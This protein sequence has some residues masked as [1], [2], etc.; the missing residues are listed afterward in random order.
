M[1]RHRPAALPTR[2]EPSAKASPLAPRAV[3]REFHALLDSGTRLVVD[4]GSRREPHSLLA[5]GYT[6]KLAFELF[7][8]RFYLA[9]VR[10]N[11]LLRFFVAWVVPPGA[12]R[13]HA[14]IFYK[15]VSL[16]W[17]CGS[18]GLFTDAELWIGKGATRFERRGGYELEHTIES[19]T[20]LPFEMQ[21]VLDELMRRPEVI[22]RDTEVLARVLRNAP[23]HR[24][25][26]YADFLEPRRRAMADPRNRIHGG[27]PIARFRRRHDPGSLEIAAG[28]EPDFRRGRI[29]TTRGRSASYGGVVE[30]HRIL[31]RNRRVQWL[32]FAAPRHVWPAPPQALTTELSSYGVRTV[33]VVV[34]DE[35]CLPGYEYHYLND[36]EF[37]DSLHSQI[38]PGFAGPANPIDPDRADASAW[39]DRLPVVAEF[40]RQVQR[41]R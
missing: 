10:Q 1:S 24:L 8:H 34:P 18:H 35:L 3:V 39:L 30:R 40:R 33:D 32:F 9:N 36:P 31:S 4:G 5:D 21:D 20:D 37:E 28:F 29:E 26:P 15:D 17:R 13:A 6:P 2:V 12:E 11:P 14:R 38:P 7:G 27:R 41:R 25:A 22:R 23:A 19:T 16:I